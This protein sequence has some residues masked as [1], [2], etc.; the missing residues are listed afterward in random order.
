MPRGDVVT[1]YEDGQWKNAIEGSS[2]QLSSHAKFAAAVAAGRQIALLRS[3]EHS[4]QQTGA[5]VAGHK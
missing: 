2:R 5:Q 3:V 4:V 1:Y